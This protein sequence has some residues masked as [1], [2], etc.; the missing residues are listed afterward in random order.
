MEIKATVAPTGFNLAHPELH[1]YTSLSGLEGILR[2]RTLWAT[3]FQHLN[4]RSEVTHLEA[5]LTKAVAARALPILN[6]LRESNRRILGESRIAG[7]A[8][9]YARRHA[10]TLVGSF[11]RVAFTGGTV[12]PMA[13]PLILSFCS[14][15][16]GQDYEQENGLLSQW[17]GYGEGG[18]YCIVFDTQALLDLMLREWGQFYWIGYGIDEVVYAT[19]NISV[20][21]EYATLVLEFIRAI[22]HGMLKGLSSIQASATG[23]AHFLVV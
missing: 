19:P 17:R 20:S 18:G 23:I 21:A 9:E 15:S 1:H 11:Y 7:G 14:H 10:K 3:H 12:E 13:V 16:R 6:R 22:E 8:A 2:S 5:E 4:D